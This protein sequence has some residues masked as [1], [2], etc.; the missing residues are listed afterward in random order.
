VT[1]FKKLKEENRRMKE[2]INSLINEK[3]EKKIIE[4]VKKLK[5]L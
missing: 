5:S 4:K 3:D 2:I 1:N